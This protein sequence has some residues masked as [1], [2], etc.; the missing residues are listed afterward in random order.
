[1]YRSKFIPWP[2]TSD[3]N[4]LEAATEVCFEVALTVVTTND[5]NP[6]RALHLISNEGSASDIHELLAPQVFDNIH[7]ETIFPLKNPKDRRCRKSTIPQF[8]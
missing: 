6:L 7:G 5:W 8:V 4:P 2:Y 3:K 1:M